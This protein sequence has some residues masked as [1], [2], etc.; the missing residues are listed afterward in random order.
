MQNLHAI[1]LT[2]KIANLCSHIAPILWQK[3]RKKIIAYCVILKG[4]G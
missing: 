4:S 2:L 1:L 3:K